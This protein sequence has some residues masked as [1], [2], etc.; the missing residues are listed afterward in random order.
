[1]QELSDAAIERH[2]DHGNAMPTWKSTM[3]LYAIDGAASRVGRDE[4][5]WAYRDAKWAR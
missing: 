2:V 5:P 3:H 1:V 4:T